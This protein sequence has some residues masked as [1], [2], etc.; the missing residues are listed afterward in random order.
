MNLRLPNSWIRRYRKGPHHTIPETNFAALDRAGTSLFNSKIR[1]K[2]IDL[3][4]YNADLGQLLFGRANLQG[5]YSRDL[6]HH[7]GLVRRYLKIRSGTAE[8]KFSQG[9]L[10]IAIDHLK[11]EVY[12][13]HL[14]LGLQDM[15]FPE[16]MEWITHIGSLQE[17]A[18]EAL[19]EIGMPASYK[20]SVVKASE[21]AR[22]R[23]GLMHGKEISYQAWKRR[24]HGGKG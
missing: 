23:T 11:K 7:V 6:A 17:L 16:D 5:G 1:G 19:R 15:V 8:E 3:Y 22:I 20:K 10:D 18:M 13:K 21:W 2:P 9:S 12:F 4:V 14:T 24:L